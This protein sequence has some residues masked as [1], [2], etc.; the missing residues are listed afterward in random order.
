MVLQ[1]KNINLD[2]QEKYKNVYL[3][4]IGIDSN[5]N[6]R[7]IEIIHIWGVDI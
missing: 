3:V 6:N 1:R 2:I 4:I 5:Q 7:E